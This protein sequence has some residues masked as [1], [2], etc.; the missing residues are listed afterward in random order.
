MQD[1]SAKMVERIA[2]ILRVLAAGDDRGASLQTIAESLALKKPTAHRILSALTD[3]G[4]V[5]QD[6]TTRNYRLGH[7]AAVLG[8]TAFEQDIAG[9]ARAS[10]VR[11]AGLSGDTAFASAIEGPAAICVAREVGDFP[12]R[13]LTLSVGDRRPLG[14]GA[15]SLA[16]LAALPGAAIERALKRNETWLRDFQGFDAASLRERVA[17]TQARGYAE[18]DGRI[19]SG[20]AGVA[21]P[22]LDADGLPLAALSLAAIRDRMTPERIPELVQALRAEAAVVAAHLRYPRVA[23]A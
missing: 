14:V 13:T 16:L 4:L 17:E 9:A 1:I 11:L 20:M 21:V 10:L 12:I 23:A 19:V 3:N 22:V 5:F 2:A 6:M 15:G 8:R 7:A 18:N